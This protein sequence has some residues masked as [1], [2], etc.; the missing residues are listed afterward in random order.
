MNV[1]KKGTNSKIGKSKVLKETIL[2]NGSWT[3]MVEISYKDEKKNLRKWEGL[4][5]KKKHT[6]V[7]IVAK[8]K[9]SGRYII[10]RQF[11]PPINSY[12]L[13]FP[14]GLVDEGEE[15]KN[16]AKRELLEE[17]GFSGKVE[18]ES[19]KLLSS[20]GIISETVSF[21]S[22]TVDEENKENQKPIQ[23]TEPGEFITVFLKYPHEIQEFFENESKNGVLYDAKLFGYFM[24]QGIL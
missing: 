13:E 6:A 1:L 15:I 11:R 24:A 7:I 2:Y 14:A 4:H 17:T 5:R 3:E 21:V 20:P 8:L 12:I 23:K 18:N 16:A 10:I 22:V 9:P 19:P